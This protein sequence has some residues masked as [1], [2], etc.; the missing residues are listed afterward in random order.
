MNWL[1]QRLRT[2]LRISV[3]DVRLG[4]FISELDRPWAETPF[5]IQGFLL[6]KTRHLAI[7][8]RLVK[9]VTIDP[10]RSTTHALDHLPW[11]VLHE[12]SPELALSAS[13]AARLQVHV[14]VD[15][16]GAAPGIPPGQPAP[17][18]LRYGSGQP[19]HEPETMSGV[20]RQATH[21]S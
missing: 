13:P 7:L 12:P 15:G 2:S 4:M 11:D 19:N 17:Y 5:M 8:K 6:Q 18:Y 10:S 21:V 3:T 16:G 9:E 14:D 1:I 20:E